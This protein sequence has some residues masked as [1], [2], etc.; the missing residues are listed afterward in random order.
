MNRAFPIA[1]GSAPADNGD[2]RFRVLPGWFLLPMTLALGGC[3]ELADHG[4]AVSSS[5][6]SDYSQ[7]KYDGAAPKRETYVFMQGNY[8]PGVIADGS[9]QR[10][11]FRRVAE[12]LAPEL[13][14]R[15]FWPAP[16]ASSADLVLVVH[17]GVT[18][19]S[20]KLDKLLAQDPPSRARV[21]GV[22][23][24]TGV[25]Y[26]AQV[27][28]ASNPSRGEP[29][30]SDQMVSDTFVGIAGADVM[31]VGFQQAVERTDQLGA[32]YGTADAMKLLGYRRHLQ[33]MAE[34]PFLTAEEATLRSD[35]ESERYFVVIQAYDLRQMRG[36]KP[37][38][39]WTLH[40]NMRSAG[41]NFREA[42]AMMGNV[43]VNYFGRNVDRVDTALPKV[44]QGQVTIGEITI[45]GE[46][47]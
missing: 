38:L 21:A 42:V 34:R 27:T 13:A 32:D 37:R 10:L 31:S 5:A 9:L 43:A 7:A 14:K 6:F 4:V 45:V 46:S 3:A 35:L 30:V 2:M 40:L 17:W 47:R 29:L 39:V 44:R 26:H 23:A 25:D 33:K 20:E 18:S 8:F 16:A 1:C 22:D 41:N 15:A 11:P 28:D 19:P 12:M 36:R 24:N